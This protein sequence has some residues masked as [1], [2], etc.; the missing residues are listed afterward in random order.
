M[1]SALKLGDPGQTLFPSVVD[2][3]VAGPEL[4]EAHSSRAPSLCCRKASRK[5]S[6]LTRDG[7]RLSVLVR[8]LLLSVPCWELQQERSGARRQKNCES[9]R[10]T[11]ASSKSPDFPR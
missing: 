10:P 11:P 6:E 5:K 9:P 1:S 2:E 8:G 7:S 3:T 4:P